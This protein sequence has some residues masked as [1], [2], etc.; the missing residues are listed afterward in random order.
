MLYRILS[1]ALVCFVSVSQAAEVVE[2]RDCPQCPPMIVVPEGSFRM[3]SNDG[4]RTRPEG[5]IRLVAVKRAFALGKFELTLAEF[6]RFVSATG[7][8][9]A[10][11][12]RA[13]G[14]RDAVTARV[15]LADDAQASWQEPR[16]ATRQAETA[17]VVCV[18]RID[19]LAY[20][21]WLS[22]TTGKIYRLPSEA[23][24]EYAA[25]A[26][27]SSI[28]PWGNNPD[29]GCGYANLYDQAGRKANDFGWGFVDCDD[30]AAE[31]SQVGRY[32]ANAFGLH[33]MIG[34]VW[35]WTADCY[36]ET[37][38]NAPVDGSAVAGGTDCALWSVRGGA[39]MTRPSRQRLS[40]RGRDPNDAR[41][42]FFGF[43]VAR[44]I[45]GSEIRALRKP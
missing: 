23:E 9:V 2:F 12:C 11:G 22:Q 29:N 38:D 5:P 1:V 32:A 15:E 37:Y 28:Y 41:Y 43:R 7:Y 14:K 20:V 4:E 44:N 19:A 30:G 10:P 21:A 35:E 31:L 39:W 25:G 24:W 34:N 36:R 16:F 6:R 3:G 18:G 42:S 40:F 27:A 33:D 8:Q 26:G 13:Q 17:P 45:S